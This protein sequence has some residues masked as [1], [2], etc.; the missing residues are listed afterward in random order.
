MDQLAIKIIILIASSI[1]F[2]MAL[3]MWIL[4]NNSRG[5]NGP[6][7]WS[8]ANFIIG[9]AL[10]FR[11]LAP[12][13]SFG[14]RAISMMAVSI[15]LYIYLSGIWQFNG[16]KI[17]K[18]VVFGIPIFDLIQTF[19]FFFWFP[20]NEVRLA[21]HI[22]VLIIFSSIAVYEMLYPG[23]EKQ[24][25]HKIFIINALF[26]GA[27]LFMS[28]A[29]FV[30]VLIHPDQPQ[31]IE[32]IWLVAFGVAGGIMT[33]ITF[34]FLSA[35][36]LE[37]YVELKGQLR[38]KTKFFSIIAH[39]LKGPVGTLM[40]FLNL[41]NNQKDLRD[42]QK[43]IFLE[44]LEVLS[45]STFHLLQNLLEWA[46]SS[47]NISHFE[48]DRL[49]LN[50]IIVS[51]IKFYESLTLFKSIQLEFQQKDPAFI[52]GNS[53]MIETVIR[54][55][56]SNAIKFTSKGGKIVIDAKKVNDIILLTIKDTGMGIEQKRLNQIFELE[57]NSLTKGTEGE[58]GSG[59]G[60]VLCKEFVNKNNGVI[61]IESVENKGTIVIVEFPAVH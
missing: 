6:I 38:T 56:V 45:Q 36:N 4:H 23:K 42:D 41:L 54:N 9:C 55:L 20:N 17:I 13:S 50:Q 39:D 21:I 24:H 30:L 34:G 51:N 61:R 29:G 57:N 16:K 43:E 1:S 44:N 32:Y 46:H 22:L 26:F 35:V 15:G 47:N 10:V 5:I 58:S 27:F 52:M 12:T 60:L 28:L 40:N 49:D 33:A 14:V 7:Y 19:V 18:W 59:L 53:K 25:L 37:L 2:I 48:V 11:F 8:V 3:Y 31:D